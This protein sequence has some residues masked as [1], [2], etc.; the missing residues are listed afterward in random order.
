MLG[1]I[2]AVVMAS[3]IP[4]GMVAAK[5]GRAGRAA[6]AG[7]RAGRIVRLVRL[8]RLMRL[9]KLV[10]IGRVFA[11]VTD[12]VTVSERANKSG[13]L[14]VR[15]MSSMV[16]L[17][18]RFKSARM[19]QGEQG[20][21]G[22]RGANDDNEFDRQRMIIHSGDERSDRSSYL[23]RCDRSSYL[24]RSDRSSYFSLTT[25]EHSYSF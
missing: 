7:T 3:I 19:E 23:E 22:E 9:T 13:E 20:G 11:A 2:P 18:E 15:R 10:R 12:E 24:E 21:G 1:D 8:T 16:E 14:S 5:A 17:A 4:S 25:H 6:R